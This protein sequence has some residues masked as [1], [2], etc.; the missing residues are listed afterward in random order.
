[1][2]VITF[3]EDDTLI[4]KILIDLGLW[5]THNH[6]PPQSNYEPIPTIE[7]AGHY[8]II[9]NQQWYRHFRLRCGGISVSECS[10]HPTKSED[11]LWLDPEI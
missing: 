11:F 9:N 2:K 3:I 4:K 5:Q 8:K 6:D 1:M 7:K 10:G